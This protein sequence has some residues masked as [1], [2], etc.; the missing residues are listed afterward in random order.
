[1]KKQVAE[2]LSITPN[3]VMFKYGY[4]PQILDVNN[5]KKLTETLLE[6]GDLLILEVSKASESWIS[7]LQSSIP[8]N[9]V[10]DQSGKIMVRRIIPADNSCLFNAISYALYKTFNIKEHGYTMRKI[11]QQA[12]SKDPVNYNSA[13]LEKTNEEYQKWILSANAWGGSIEL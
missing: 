1:M 3:Q 4:P 2:K 7:A 8:E 13:I 6:D 11:I 5:S 12:I 10:P 9:Q